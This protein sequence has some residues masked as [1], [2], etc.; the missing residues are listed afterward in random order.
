MIGLTQNQLRVL[1]FIERYMTQNNGVSPSMVEISAFLGQASKSAAHRVLT[2]LE[3]RGRIRRLPNRAR[4]IE[5][6][7]PSLAPSIGG[8]PL[9]FIPVHAFGDMA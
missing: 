1:H 6:I 8:I 9:R 3:E 4:A 7:K 5:V 2:A